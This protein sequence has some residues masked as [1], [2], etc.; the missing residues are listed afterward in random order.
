[1]FQVF[2]WCSLHS[3]NIF[4]ILGQYYQIWVWESRAHHCICFEVRRHEDVCRYLQSLVECT[5]LDGTARE[6]VAVEAW[7]F[8]TGKCWWCEWT[9]E[10][11]I[12][13]IANQGNWRIRNRIWFLCVCFCSDDDNASWQDNVL[14]ALLFTCQ[15]FSEAS[16]PPSAELLQS[17]ETNLKTKHSDVASCRRRLEKILEKQCLLVQIANFDD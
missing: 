17:Y 13:R 4:L 5:C 7:S 16:Q 3:R 1:M 15:V 14:I 8:H 2:Q 9:I 11:Y 10:S 12:K 6:F